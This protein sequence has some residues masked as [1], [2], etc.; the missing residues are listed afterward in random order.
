MIDMEKLILPL[1]VL[2]QIGLNELSTK[3]PYTENEKH[4]KLDKNQV[5]QTGQRVKYRLVSDAKDWTELK[6]LKKNKSIRDVCDKEV[7]QI[8]HDNKVVQV[9]YIG[10][11]CG[12]LSTFKKYNTMLY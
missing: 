2:D 1:Q 8:G 11:S 9:P 3:D 6:G 7:P 4:R 5:P 12:L 10:Q